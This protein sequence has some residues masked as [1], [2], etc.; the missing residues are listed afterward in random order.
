M[1]L[2]DIANRRFGR[3]VAIG[4]TDQI[5]HHT[6]VWLCHCDCGNDRLVPLNDLTNKIVRSC[7]C[8]SRESRKEKVKMLRKAR[9]KSLVDGT[10]VS[11]LISAP[12]KRS[13]TGVRGVCPDRGKYRAYITFQGKRHYLGR[14]EKPEDAAKARK[15][16]EDRLWGEFFEK[17]PELKEGK[18]DIGKKFD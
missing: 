1:N 13:Q 8:L 5:R 2:K 16:A 11:V 9:E 14:Y 10:D 3:L 6:R 15:Q 18:K 7:G 4:P 17:H 12:D